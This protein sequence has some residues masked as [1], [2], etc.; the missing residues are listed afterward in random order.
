MADKSGRRRPLKENAVKS[1]EEVSFGVDCG[2]QICSGAK[3]RFG[4]S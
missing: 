3:L 1:A 2:K 4:R